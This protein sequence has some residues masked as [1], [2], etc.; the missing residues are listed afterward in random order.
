M[1][2]DDNL[3]IDARI[4]QSGVNDGMEDME[5]NVRRGLDAIN[6]TA[7]SKMNVFSGFFVA[8]A[9]AAGQVIYGIS[10]KVK[11][12][13]ASMLTSGDEYNKAM[14]QLSASTG[15]VGEELESLK[16]VA[17]DVFSN[18]YGES[19]DD[20]ANA[21]ANVKK[22]LG[23]LPADQ[24]QTITESAF[25]LSDTFEYDVAESTRAA[26]AMVDNFGISG[27]YAM[28]LI[29][30]GTKNNLN[31]SDELIDSINE[32]SV[33]FAKVG[34]NADDMFKIF[35]NGAENGAWNL[36]KIGDAVKEFSIRAIDGS[37]ST[38]EG[39]EAVGLNADE[40]AWK[41]TQGGDTAKTAFKQT[42]AALISME[43]PIARDAAGVALFGTMW[44]DLGVDAVAS[45][46]NI[47]DGAYATSDAMNAI[48]SVKYNDIGSA[49]EGLKRSIGSFTI[50]ASAAF[51]TKIAG[52]I[53]TLVNAINSADGDISVIF[54]GAINALKQVGSAFAEIAS[55]WVENG[56][57]IIE[58]LISG[59]KEN[60]PKVQEKAGEII[61]FLVNGFL[62]SRKQM[63]EVAIP[64]IQGLVE[65]ISEKIPE[66]MNE[67]L[68]IFQ[69]LVTGIIDA[70]PQ[71]LPLAINIITSLING[72]SQA[73]VAILEFAPQI[74]T[75]II[76]GIIGVL[77]ELIGCAIQI[78]DALI[79]AIIDNL[80]PI[81]TACLQI[82]MAIVNGIIDNLDKLI[83]AAF[84]IIQ[85]LIDELLKNDNLQKILDATIDIIMAITDGIIDNLDKLIDAAFQII[86]KIISELL[87]EDN[88]EKL[89][90]TGIELLVK[91]IVGLCRFAGRLAEFATKLFTTLGE[92]IAKIDWSELGENI[93]N[94]I[95]SGLTGVDFDVDEFTDDFGDNWITG[96]KDIFGIHSPSRL[97]RDEI[98]KWLLPGVAVGV[99]DTS[100][101]TADN[102]NSTLNKLSSQL[103][104]PEIETPDIPE[105]EFNWDVLEHSEVDFPEI[106]ISEP[107]IPEPEVE[108]P[109]FSEESLIISAPE[110]KI[111]A[112]EKIEFNQ[113][114]I[115]VMQFNMSEKQQEITPP[116]VNISEPQP[117]KFKSPEIEP[118]EIPEQ[119]KISINSPEFEVSELEPIK[120]KNPEIETPEIPEITIDSP[121]IEV[122][123]SQ[124][125]EFES[126][127][128]EFP[129]N[130]IFTQQIGL[131]REFSPSNN[132][133]KLDDERLTTEIRSRFDELMVTLNADNFIS[134]F[135]AILSSMGNTSVPQYSEVYEQLQSV[136]ERVEN[137]HQENSINTQFS[138]KI[139][140]FIGDTEIKDF[141]ISAIDE[142][143]AISG[144]A[145]V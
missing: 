61:K 123:E 59:I 77:P 28:E 11:E 67:G 99:E 111:E 31:Y 18:N 5:E 30:A 39:F 78:L 143:N 108:L 93:L 132:V 42:V 68:A 27:E 22:Q 33:Q 32:Y 66:I 87:Q 75:A 49:I 115:A 98:G 48:K 100:D 104:M 82:L 26:K 120:F 9:N 34:L 81:L 72:L 131:L 16:D 57:K 19:Y 138:P 92:E 35:Q 136:P 63:I 4:D 116:E 7:E 119:S 95:M 84:Q 38:A 56:K 106:V 134:R 125:I 114:E 40:M 85:F 110:V 20:V 97:M 105:P 96:F 86:D 144:G 1:A 47:Q 112:P 46:G 12:S 69:S 64:I 15:A 109:E 50:D 118:P 124:P 53:G 128:T 3:Q 23:D 113:P 14:N 101:E 83:D 2:Y 141:V 29:A 139:S 8:A 10:E 45:L 51:S 52:A 21:V 80:E 107:D 41:F 117:I 43:D 130:E 79:T 74:L 142:A 62:N 121:K 13:F 145:S 133:P 55:G 71:L 70:I 37:T 60:L 88:I 137:N 36:D 94:G 140:V 6:S 102:V 91:I 65:G 90:T 103:K 129:D 76:N 25:A 24:L 44:E 89:I 58:Y 54:D 73:I 122:S 17:K 135:E 127:E 126:P